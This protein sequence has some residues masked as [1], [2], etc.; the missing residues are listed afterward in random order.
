VAKSYISNTVTA[1][2]DTSILG[3]VD[4]RLELQ[5][6][7]TTREVG[8]I[9]GWREV[10]CLCGSGTPELNITFLNIFLTKLE[11]CKYI[12][13]S[14]PVENEGRLELLKRTGSPD[15]RHADSYRLR[16]KYG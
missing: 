1:A 7:V 14:V 16:Y 9:E 8:N 13:E 3:A 2:D 10:I 15:I 12:Q 4:V 11:A 6:N 5:E